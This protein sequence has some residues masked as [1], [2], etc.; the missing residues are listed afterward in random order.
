MTLMNLAALQMQEQKCRTKIK[1]KPQDMDARA[2]LAWCLFMQSVVKSTLQTCGRCDRSD[3]TETEPGLQIDRGVD[4]LYQECVFQMV[5]ITMFG[6]S[7]PAISEMDVL[8]NLLINY[9]SDVRV[10]D[11][12]RN[13]RRRFVRMIMDMKLLPPNRSANAQ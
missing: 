5:S 3:I 12:E 13:A 11:E 2:S 8:R 9:Y 6:D 4:S 1:E 7:S 10:R